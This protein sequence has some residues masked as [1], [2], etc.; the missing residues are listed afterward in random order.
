MMS[1]TKAIL[2]SLIAFFTPVSG[3]AIGM[4]LL[5]ILDTITGLVR[6]HKTGE[7][8]RSRRLGQMATKSLI[9]LAVLYMVFPVDYYLL[10]SLMML[11]FDIEYLTI[12]VIAIS[13]S[14]IELTSI[15]ENIELAFKIDIFATIKKALSRATN[16]KEDITKLK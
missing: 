14:L 7:K 9:Y 2:F 16:I 8:I 3:I 4:G 13:F 11:M 12:K 1:F 5:V 10:N 6:A 15:K